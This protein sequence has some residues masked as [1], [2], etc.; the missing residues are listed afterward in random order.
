[1]FTV[2]SSERVR[3]LERLNAKS[4]RDYP[5][6]RGR[7]GGAISGRRDSSLLQLLRRTTRE[8]RLVTW[9]FLL[10]STS[11]EGINMEGLTD[12]RRKGETDTL[13]S[14]HFAGLAARTTAAFGAR[15]DSSRPTANLA[16]DLGGTSSSL[17]RCIPSCGKG[18]CLGAALAALLCAAAAAGTKDD[19]ALR[20]LT[21]VAAVRA[22]PLSKAR[23]SLPLRLRGIVTT[24]SGWKNSFFL[25][26]GEQQQPGGSSSLALNR[27]RMSFR[28]ESRIPAPEDVFQFVV[29]NLRPRL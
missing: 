8:A 7:S 27:S 18:A 9:R 16:G 25:Q 19:A 23:Q 29:E 26:D 1:M 20:I 4:R 24:P 15:W 3:E 17:K 13:P 28:A 14:R 2:D 11:R 5:R 10:R 22:L 6:W 21:K 12:R